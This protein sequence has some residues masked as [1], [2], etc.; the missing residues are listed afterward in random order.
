MN[1]KQMQQAGEE[2]GQRQVNYI[3]QGADTLGAG[4]P[5]DQRKH[6]KGCH[7]HDPVGDAQH[8]L[9]G[10][11]HQVPDG[12][13]L[14]AGH[15]CGYSKN[16][17]EEDH[18]QHVGAGQCCYRIVRHDGHETIGERQDCLHGSGRRLGEVDAKTGPAD[19]DQQQ[20]N[21]DGQ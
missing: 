16:D 15:Q 12:P 6:T 19:A 18:R 14:L 10:S 20:P 4:H 17:S 1:D 7:F 8:D 11:V 21:G 9:G 2:D 5:G 3:H 13:R